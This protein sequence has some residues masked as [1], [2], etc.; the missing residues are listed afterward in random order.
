MEYSHKPSRGNILCYL[1]SANNIV[2]GLPA[3]ILDHLLV[4]QTYIHHLYIFDL[5]VI[6]S[7]I[8]TLLP[9]SG[10]IITMYHK[11]CIRWK[12]IMSVRLSLSGETEFPSPYFRM[13]VSSWEILYEERLIMTSSGVNDK[14]LSCVKF[15]NFFSCIWV[16]W[17]FPCLKFLYCLN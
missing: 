3:V 6:L 12:C 7:I 9:L 10:R 13:I 5:H 14:T 17:I 2:A 16:I 15:D 11:L 8:I 4:A 1:I